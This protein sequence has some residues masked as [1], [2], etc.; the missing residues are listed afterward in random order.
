MK[1][2]LLTLLIPLAPAA[3]EL[4]RA[5]DRDG[6]PP[7]PVIT[8]HDHCAWP[9]L[10][11]LK[12]GRTLAALIFN[13][14]SHGHRPGD[15]EC[16]L[17]TDGGASWSLASAATQH[18]PDTIRMNHAAGLAK[19]GDLLV[20]TSGWSNRW[21]ADQPRVRGSYRYETLRP[22]VSRSPD[23]G[24]S[25]WVEKEA[26]PEKTPGGEAATPFGDVQIAQNGDLCVAVYS[27]QGAWV[28]YEERHFR[29][30]LY[31]SKDDGKTWSE[32]AVIADAN[33]TTVLHLGDGRWLAAAR[34][35][36]GVEKKDRMTL[37]ASEDDGRTWTFKRD[38]GGYQQ[39]NGHLLQLRDGRVL[40]TYGDRASAPGQR[41]LEAMLSTDSGETWTAPV[42]LTDWNGLDGGYP[43]S[44]Q[45]QDGQIV[46]AYYASAMPDDPP[47][48][49]KGYHMAV[50]VWDADKTF[51]K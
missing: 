4:P 33:E 25:W 46:T 43:S 48:F 15:I 39:I 16:W 6:N 30:W 13:K 51:R 21:P 19:N 32:P 14:A 7:T 47:D 1:H 36:N 40:Y 45:R 10:K 27:A 49:I 44:A 12:D 9:N 24:A 50:I 17:S 34:V 22:W 35:G 37:H 29:S 18:E 20:L 41:G 38:L 2:A 28:T 3:A 31:R 8:A 23:G 11:L 5:V 26:F 42:R